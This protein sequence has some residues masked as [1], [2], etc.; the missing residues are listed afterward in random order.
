MIKAFLFDNGGVIT[1][2]GGGN[3]LSERLAKNLGI[4]PDK[5]F[6]L[7][8]PVW[9]AY[10]QGKISEPALWASIEQHYGQA[11][12]AQQRTIWNKWQD[13]QPL[14]AMV[15][16]VNRLRSDGYV[17]GLLSNVIPNTEH[18]IRTNGGY[19]MFDFVVLSCKV[20]LSKPDPKIYTTA[21]QHLP[22]I[23]PNEV[24]F[25]DDQERCL[26]PARELGM[27]TILVSDPMQAIAAVDRLITP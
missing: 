27:Q 5:A 17:V 10:A 21:M 11:I 8:M 15:E 19:E 24:V 23:E 2:G 3:E 4:A 9:D 7:L 13:M 16:L 22:G 26:L 18:E 14:P 25:L 20:G 12:T 6:D 1:A